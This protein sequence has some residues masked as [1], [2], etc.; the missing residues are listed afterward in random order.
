VHEMLSAVNGGHGGIAG[1][2]VRQM[3]EGFAKHAC[4]AAR[5]T[6]GAGALAATAGTALAQ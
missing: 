1:I 2:G 6:D 5:R 4:C 3:R